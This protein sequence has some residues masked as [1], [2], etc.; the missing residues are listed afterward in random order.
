LKRYPEGLSESGLAT[1]IGTKRQR[2]PYQTALQ[3]LEERKAIVCLPDFKSGNRAT[4]T[5]W[6]LPTPQGEKAASSIELPSQ[7]AV[8]VV[9]SDKAA[10]KPARKVRA[11]A[12]KLPS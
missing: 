10:K 4:C 11:K 9:Q 1:A 6:K 5:G 7:A 3:E 2:G 12:A 8:P